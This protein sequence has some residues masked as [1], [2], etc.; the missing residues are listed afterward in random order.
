MFNK[1]EV[2]TTPAVTVNVHSLVMLQAIEERFV[3]ATIDSD[4]ELILDCIRIEEADDRNDLREILG[5]PAN[6]KLPT[7]GYIIFW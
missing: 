2:K 6:A 5:L 7:D 4:Q 3:C 1:F